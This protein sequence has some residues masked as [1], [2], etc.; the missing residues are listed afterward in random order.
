MSKYLEISL[1][2]ILLLLF[3]T[4]QFLF[5][6]KKAYG[7]LDEVEINI[8]DK[9]SLGFV[10]KDIVMNLLS[11]DS[12]SRWCN[13]RNEIEVDSLEHAL[14]SIPYVDSVEV[15]SVLDEKLVIDILQM[16]AAFRLVVMGGDSYYVDKELRL[17]KSVNHFSLDRP[18]VSCSESFFQYIDEKSEKN[19]DKLQNLFNFVEIICAE[20]F[21][22]SMIVQIS[23]NSDEE[24]ELT[25]R[26]GSHS[27]VLCRLDEQERYHHYLSKLRAIYSKMSERDNWGRYK[28][29][30]TRYEDIVVATRYKK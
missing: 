23:L 22:E 21:W 2:V 6:S 25:P 1:V 16:D 28:K 13:I 18:V 7:N 20:P 17:V 4:T 10:T 8:L 24:I 5:E 29:I 12:I 3:A 30:D 26:V 19:C 11:V 9:D 15:Y 14:L 27:V